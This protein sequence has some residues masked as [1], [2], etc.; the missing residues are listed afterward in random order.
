MGMFGCKPK[1]P[2]TGGQPAPFNAWAADCH[3][4]LS[5]AGPAWRQGYA[6]VVSLLEAPGPLA[7]R[8]PQVAATHQQV[9]E[10]G[11]KEP[12]TG[13][14]M[15]EEDYLCAMRDALE[16]SVAR[17]AR[18]TSESDAGAADKRAS[19]EGLLQALQA[20]PWSGPKWTAV[21]LP[22][23]E[24]HVRDALSKLP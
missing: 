14:A 2:A 3:E 18:L 8:L 11:R 24:K 4:R 9:L 7:S 10:A 17:E 1:T 21:D 6:D 15:P 5:Q 16:A 20:L 13:R 22:R 23:I 12:V 19:L